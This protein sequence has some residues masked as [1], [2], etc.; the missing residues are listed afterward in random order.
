MFWKKDNNDVETDDR[1]DI[2][3]Y[4]NQLQIRDA[5]FEDSGKND[6]RLKVRLNPIIIEKY[7]T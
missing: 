5:K 2:N 1:V 6:A 4:T 7:I 3:P